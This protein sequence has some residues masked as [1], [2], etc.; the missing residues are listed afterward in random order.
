MT[1]EKTQ[2]TCKAKP[3]VSQSQ[4]RVCYDIRQ[5]LQNN[6]SWPKCVK[7]GPKLL[8]SLLLQHCQLFFLQKYDFCCE[9]SNE[10]FLV[11][12]CQLYLARLELAAKLHFYIY[13]RPRICTMIIF[14]GYKRF[15]C[16]L[17]G[18]MIMNCP[19]LEIILNP[20]PR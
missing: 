17:L 1:N 11:I 5:L 2:L 18:N 12:F 19:F 16:L 3:P 8:K 20:A 13:V 10:I 9:N 7:R 14:L 4:N 15:C 6:T